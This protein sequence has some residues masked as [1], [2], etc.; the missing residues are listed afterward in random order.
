MKQFGSVLAALLLVGNGLFTAIF[1]VGASAD[2]LPAS[3]G[4]EAFDRQPAALISQDFNINVYAP[5]PPS[6]SVD[7][8]SLPV[9]F[10]LGGLGGN[11]R[12]AWYSDLLTRI[13]SRG[14]VV[15]GLDRLSLLDYPKLAHSFSKVLDWAHQG[16]LL[17][18][19]KG[20]GIAWTPDV[21]GRAAVMGQ[22]EGNHVVGQ[23]LSYNCSV[24]QAL[25]MVDPVDG[26]DPFR[27]VKTQ[28][29]ITPGKKL[30]FNIPSLIVDNVLDGQKSNPLFPP[31]VPPAM[32]TV[33]WMQAMR[34][35]VWNINATAYGHTDCLND[36]F[37]VVAGLLC[38]TDLSTNKAAYRE[39]IAEVTSTF[40]GALFQQ[41]PD[42][43]DK[44]ED[45]AAISVTA[46]LKWDLA[47]LKHDQIKPGCSNVPAVSVLV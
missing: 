41:R 30:N 11:A 47:G 20:K 3:T 16:G 42:D 23:A 1:F 4:M 5:N 15:V 39:M 26:Y 22:S 14:F 24:A 34:G 13:V 10:F 29:L 17:E 18:F 6:P 32:G 21:A 8:K 19:M 9:I 12:A 7:D 35:P 45:P 44:L 36:G 25:V 37:D 2:A 31:C 28:D 43:F 40:L 38:K 46:T 27:F 33:R